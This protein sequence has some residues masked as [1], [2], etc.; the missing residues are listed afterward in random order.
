MPPAPE[1]IEP[2]AMN[3]AAREPGVCLVAEAR[4]GEAWLARISAALDATKAATL[5]LFAPEGAA[6]DRKATAALV[7]AAQRKSVAA[8]LANDVATAR[9]VEA[10]GVHLSSRPEIEDAYEAARNT[11]GPDAIIGADPGLSRHDAMTLG[12][13][14]A[15]YVAFSHHT[16]AAGAEEGNDLQTRVAWWAEIFVVPVVAFG[17]ETPEEASAMVAAGADFVAV[18]LPADAAPEADTA[19]AK[20]LRAALAPPAH[21]A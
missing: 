21:A 20:A 17:I 12:E 8:L 16:D 6:F 10:D 14:G 15:D 1:G 5:I 3:K 13:A 18:S 9:E 11:L 2:R 7:E 19:W 4:Q